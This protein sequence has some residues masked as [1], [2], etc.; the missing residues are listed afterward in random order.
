MI[1]GVVVGRSS[2]KTPGLVLIKNRSCKQLKIAQ[3]AEAH[4]LNSPQGTV[5]TLL[6]RNDVLLLDFKLMKHTYSFTRPDSR[7][8]LG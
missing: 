6:R 4:Q 8:S 3:T 1:E 2:S 7:T 5:I